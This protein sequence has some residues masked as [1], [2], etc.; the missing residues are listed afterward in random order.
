VRHRRKGIDPSSRRRRG[1]ELAPRRRRRENRDC[2]T[3]PYPDGHVTVGRRRRGL[4]KLTGVYGLAVQVRVHEPDGH[5][6][7]VGAPG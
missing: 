3:S 1:Y 4:K 2:K 5:V 7:C 6:I